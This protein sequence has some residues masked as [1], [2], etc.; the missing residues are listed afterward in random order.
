[1]RASE[2]IYVGESKIPT[3]V[4]F[5]ITW[6]VIVISICAIVYEIAPVNLFQCI[7]IYFLL[8]WITGLPFVAEKFLPVHNTKD[9]KIDEIYKKRLIKRHVGGEVISYHR[10]EK[11]WM[12][13][14][15]G[16]T[17]NVKYNKGYLLVEED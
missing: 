6:N 17:L 1:M 3:W 15:R 10:E 16:K 8:W 11:T 13:L 2:N 14:D 7:M 12:V 4:K 9:T 5:F